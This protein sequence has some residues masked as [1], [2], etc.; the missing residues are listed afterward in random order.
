M[1]AVLLAST[2][3]AAEP[4]ADVP[5]THWAHDAIQRVSGHGIM[6]GFDGK[7][8]GEKLINRYQ[9]AVIVKLAIR[10][11]KYPWMDKGEVD[12]P[13]VPGTHWARKAIHQAVTSGVMT[14]HAPEGGTPGETYE[15]HKLITRYQLAAIVSRFL[16]GRGVIVDEAEL[17]ADVPASHPL[18]GAISIALGARALDAFEGRFEGAKLVNRFQMARTLDVIISPKGPK[19][20]L[21]APTSMP[22]PP[23][24][25]SSPRDRK[26]ETTEQLAI[27]LADENAQLSVRVEMLEKELAKY[28]A[29]RA[30][31]VKRIRALEARL[32]HK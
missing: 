12:F 18:A 5:E 19:M 4:Y 21:G 9:M 17:P 20:R 7:F 22:A 32:K 23:M 29:N 26:L 13:D 28:K 6:A 2:S 10:T 3:A 8:H 27:E 11:A 31:L 14:A 1:A 25:T 30:K 16:A 15:G 24:H